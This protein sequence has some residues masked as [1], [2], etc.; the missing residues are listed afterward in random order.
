MEGRKGGGKKQTVR[1]T[2]ERK[3]NIWLN[4]SLTDHII[5]DGILGIFRLQISATYTYLIITCMTFATKKN[6]HKITT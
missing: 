3:K 2:A 5:E 1:I 6:R 4:I